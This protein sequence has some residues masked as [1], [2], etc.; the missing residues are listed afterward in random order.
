MQISIYS[1]SSDILF[2]FLQSENEAITTLNNGS[3]TLIHICTFIHVHSHLYTCTHKET[4][5][6]IHICP[7]LTGTHVS[8]Y[9]HIYTYS[10]AQF[11]HNLIV[12]FLYI[13][14]LNEKS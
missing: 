11:T 8:L 14:N 12:L 9:I 10:H 13:I 2:L 7:K 6:H 1:Q 5:I 3:H 4:L